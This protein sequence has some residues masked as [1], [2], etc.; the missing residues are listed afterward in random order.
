MTTRIA[1]LLFLCISIL[2]PCYAQKDSVQQRLFLVGDAGELINGKIP[3]V[4]WLKEKVNWNDT[5]NTILFL[6]D[7][8]YPA[9]LP[10][11]GAPGYKEAKRIL[12]YQIDVVRGKKSK[13]FFIPGN[14]DWMNAAPGCDQQMMNQENYING[15]EQPNIRAYPTDACPGPVVY[16]LDNKVVLVFGDS[17]WFLNLGEKP[18]PESA[19]S[20]KTME[21]FV[22]ELNEI[23]EAHK[24]QL[25]VLAMHHPFYTYGLHGGDYTW[26]DH[27]FPFTA[28]SPNLYIPLPVIGSA[29]PIARGFFGNVQDIYHPLYRNMIDEI[30]N[31]MKKHP[32]PIQ[33]AGHDHGLQLN[34]KDSIPYIVSGSGSKLTRL[35]KGTYNV[36]YDLELGFSMLE[37]LKNGQ[38]RVNFYNVHSRDL[39]DPIFVRDLRPIKPVIPV[40]TQDTN[41]V[42]IPNYVTVAPDERLKST[43]IKDFLVGKNYRDDWV[44][45]VRIPVLDLNKEAGGLQP[46]RQSGGGQLRMLTLQDKQ[47]K[48][49]QLRSIDRFPQAVIP[50]DL[51][52]P[53]DPNLHEDANS[54]AYPFASLIVSELN[55]TAGIP[56]PAQKLL[57][58]PDD[59]R[60]A[61]F[62]NDFKNSIGIL[63]ESG[64]RGVKSSISTSQLILN[65]QK[66]NGYDVDQRKVLRARLMD[67]FVFN[68]NR[69]ENQ[70]NWALENN[71]QKLYYPIPQNG[72][73]AFFV[74]EGVIPKLAHR[75]LA[76]PEIQG[77]DPTADNIRT[78]NKQAYSFDNAFLNKLTEQDWQAEIDTFLARVDD[79]AIVSAFNQ[80]VVT[81]PSPDKGIIISTLQQRRKVFKDEMMQ[82]YRF[83][84][85]TITIKGTKLKE[86]YVVQ[87]Q[88]DGSV[89]VQGYQAA[90]NAKPYQQN[91]E[92]LF[93][94]P[95]TREIR[96][97]GM[98][99][100]D[101]ISISGGK[102]PILIR[103]IGGPGNDHF[104]NSSSSSRVFL[105]DANFEQN[106][107]TGSQQFIN[108]TSA[109]PA[110]NSFDRNQLQHD[111]WKPSFSLAYNR[112]QGILLGAGAEYYKTG[113]RKSPFG[114]RHS[115]EAYY[116]AGTRS[117]NF[118]WESDFTDVI[119]VLDM[120]L[121]AN[122]KAPRNVTNFFG[123]GNQSVYYKD[124]P[125]NIDYYRVNYQTT[126]VSAMIRRNLQSWMFADIG[127]V[128]KYYNIESPKGFNNLDDIISQNNTLTDPKYFLGLEGKLD[129]NTKNNLVLPSRG[130]LFRI[131]A[132][133]L[134]GVNRTAYPVTQM[135]LD[136]SFFMSINPNTKTVLGTRFGFGHNIGNF[137]F[138][139]A[140]YLGGTDNLR[141]FR[142]DRFAGRTI[143]F[144]NTELRLRLKQFK[145]YLFPGSFGLLFFNDLGRVWTDNDRSAKWHDG[146]GGGVWFSPVQ[147][148]VFTATAAYSDDK[149]LLPALSFGFQF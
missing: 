39:D 124:A 82:Y 138:P 52:T 18:G 36:F 41:S 17:Q 42:S 21:E 81:L 29:Y 33:V 127:P 23:I 144:N 47:K 103:L 128:F 68:F 145:T 61:R 50:S 14:H 143:A 4:D 28:L 132:R 73:M 26:K 118:K 116:A 117:S 109:D 48:T 126:D 77:F 57:Y 88:D 72:N 63:E 20:A 19:C 142:R 56:A 67:N 133:Q 123:F 106:T 3:V 66:E 90:G 49:W 40:S 5:L 43:A 86:S 45:P 38:V 89:K 80:Q 98:E 140:Q 30:E 54:A 111:Y 15:L 6:G 11:P 136:L 107:I 137:E 35:K 32:N 78:F 13:G 114:A 104:V 44:N 121:R 76:I 120:V 37:V 105:Y 96:I 134:F 31:A 110:V 102:S 62:R 84:S 60:L 2:K 93:R 34:I 25:F 95:D 129:V 55:K 27:I 71:K 65:L 131:Y 46:V 1:L 146:Y 10:L 149:E 59:P 113:F 69:N 70:W 51:R 83:L 16:E 85:K 79:S 99:G 122:V 100:D 22:T 112:D 97:Y 94:A 141:G 139:L 101:S 12:D 9:G 119:G 64:P 75:M 92:R 148:F 108:R 115:L 147:R 24:N 87:V 53:I 130:A 58:V 8:I 7:N 135:G 125:G 74:S 91:Y